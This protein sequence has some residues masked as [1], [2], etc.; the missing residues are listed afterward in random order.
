MFNLVIVYQEPKQA[1]VLAPWEQSL[2]PVQGCMWE[3]CPMTMSFAER[4]PA[5][6]SA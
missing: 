5:R 2:A 6:I 4:T 1:S 3:A